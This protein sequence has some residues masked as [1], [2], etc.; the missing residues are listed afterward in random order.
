MADLAAAEELKKKVNSKSGIEDFFNSET[1]S[2][3]TVV[4]TTTGAQYK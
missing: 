2:D 4:N 3:I 1:L